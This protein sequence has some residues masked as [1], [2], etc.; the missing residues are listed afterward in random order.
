MT[1]ERLIMAIGRLERALSRAQSHGDNLISN[2]DVQ[3]NDKADERY[4]QLEK[5]H[6]LLKEQ[7]GDALAAIDSIISQKAGL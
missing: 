2:I 1:Q 7:A 6:I 5:K 4:Q 3:S